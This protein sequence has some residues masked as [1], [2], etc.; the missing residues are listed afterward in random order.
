M[1]LES[2]AQFLE[3]EEFGPDPLKCRIR[4]VTYYG[5]HALDMPFI[6]QVE[7]N[8]WQGG[9]RSDLVLPAFFEHM[10]S[11][12]PWETYLIEHA[13][14]SVLAV[15]MYDGDN[16][17]SAEVTSIGDWAVYCAE[18]G[19]TLIHCQAGVN[20]SS[21]IVSK[22]LR[23][24]HSEMTGQQIIDFMREKRS[25]AVLCNPTFEKFVQGI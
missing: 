24:M 16:I 23:K 12:Y 1:S 14:N 5:H 4:D 22:V 3:K 13:L 21:L 19:P 2:K 20:R 8:L 7:G 25:P 11:L 6:T 9:C 17:D 15:S 18:K 10:I